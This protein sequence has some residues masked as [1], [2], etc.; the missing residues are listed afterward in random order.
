MRLL[1]SPVQETIDECDAARK[2]EKRFLMF[3]L[4]LFSLRMAFQNPLDNM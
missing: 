3:S 4:D 2:K 1:E